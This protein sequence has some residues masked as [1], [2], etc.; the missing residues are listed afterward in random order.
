VRVERR[1]CDT[2][3]VGERQC[4]EQILELCVTESTVEPDRGCSI[5]DER[6]S[7]QA[8]EMPVLGELGRGG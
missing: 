8:D 3:P 5:A 4:G 1:D 2:Q 7:P 6:P